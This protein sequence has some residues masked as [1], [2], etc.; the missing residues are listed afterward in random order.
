[1]T[2][3]FNDPTEFAGELR[4]GF[5]AAN[6]SFVRGVEGGVVRARPSRPGRVSVVIGGGS[7]HYPAFAGLVGPGLADGA[8]MGDLFASPSAHAVHSVAR[9]AENGGGVLLACG[10]YAGDVLNF[11]AAADRL[12][13]DGIDSRTVWVT[14]DIS[15]ASP[16]EREKRRG[17]AGG[18][19]VYKVASAAAEE[20]RSLDEVTI[21]ARRANDRTRSL[22]V[23]FGGC[24]LPGADAP[25]FTV[26]E[27]RMAI[28]MGIHG[29]PGIDEAPVPRADELGA[30]LVESLLAEL[31]EDVG[32]PAGGRV[33]VVLNGLG[34]VK[35]EELFVLFGSVA[36]AFAAA[37][38]ELAF[39]EVG[40][41]TTSFDMAGLS[42]TVCWLD[43]E[44][45]RL[46]SAPASTPSY[47]TGP[48]VDGTSPERLPVPDHRPAA[49]QHPSAALADV[50][51][52]AS[53]ASR[54]AARLVGEALEAARATIDRHVDEL[55][56]LD[57]VAG[58]GDHGIG[59]Q[60]GAVAAAAAAGDAIRRGA[61]AGTVLT[62][63]GAAWADRAGG[64]SG[65]LWGLILETLGAQVGDLDIPTTAQ[66]AAGAAA[67]A[68]RVQSTGGAAP[69]DKTMVDALVPF[70]STLT[71]KQQLP[72]AVAWAA[73]VGAAETAAA[74]TA[75]LLPRMGRARPH[76]E[77][78]LGHPDPGAYSFAL[79]VRAVGGA[80]DDSR[81][82]SHG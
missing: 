10:N 28:G 54:V 47:R 50:V 30:L 78:S 37:G 6:S 35:Y 58:D 71:E 5:L 77:K 45:E 66:L 15:S 18:L 60:R 75:D 67:A 52:A 62:R 59:M 63:A 61:G 11:T 48:S 42:L 21:V 49:S 14:D 34:S 7:G 16:A 46:W 73:A 68:R 1:M 25:L 57:A 4:A 17:I 55:G 9:A 56:R 29:E 69:G 76:A 23:A 40:E 44:L 53:D 36:E 19:I 12:R 80:I 27:G 2:R 70:A 8:A 79:V 20:G 41:F 26:P 81:T 82:H 31:P 38:V 22:G 32:T 39:T 3:L 43:E 51:P 33:L 65:M 74:A 24:S 64:T 72:L 13:A